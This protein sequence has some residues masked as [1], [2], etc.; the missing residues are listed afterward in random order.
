MSKQN[1]KGFDIVYRVVEHMVNYHRDEISWQYDRPESWYDV[2]YDGTQ[3]EFLDSLIKYCDS[4]MTA[5]HYQTEDFLYWMKTMFMDT[6]E[7]RMNVLE[8]QIKSFQDSPC[9]DEEFAH[10]YQ[11]IMDHYDD[12][13]AM[14]A[15]ICQ[16]Y[17]NTIS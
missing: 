4:D 10:T 2:C 14:G 15:L 5:H 7:S 8:R 11:N 3:K 1:Q 17:R 9:S 16:H 6:L 13:E 12:I